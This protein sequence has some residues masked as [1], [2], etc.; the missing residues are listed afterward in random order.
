[1]RPTVEESLAEA[2]ERQKEW[3]EGDATSRWV[4]VTATAAA[5]GEGTEKDGEDNITIQEGDKKGEKIAGG[6]CWHVYE[7]PPF[8]ADADGHG[9]GEG[10][11]CYWWP[12]EG[13][14]RE[15]ADSVMGQIMQVRGERMVRPC[16]LLE[17]CYVHPS[18]RRLGAGSMLVSYGIKIADELGLEAFVEA[19]KDGVPL[20]EK[21]GFRVVDGILLKGELEGMGEELRKLQE[22]LTWEGMYMWRPKGG[23]WEEGTKVPWVK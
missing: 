16:L 8:G 3:H 9:E 5:G 7:K 10:M 20:Y 19:T 13:R 11:T 6:A 2:T 18:Y 17:I 1:N 22:E 12:E 14:R 21:F 15:L 23:V 4:M